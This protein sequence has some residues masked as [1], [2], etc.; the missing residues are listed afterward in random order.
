MKTFLFLIVLAMS[1][2]P[3]EAQSLPDSTEAASEQRLV[4]LRIH[5]SMSIWHSKSWPDNGFTQVDFLQPSAGIFWGKDP[6]Q[7]MEL[8]VTRMRAANRTLETY[9]WDTVSGREEVIRERQD[10]DIDLSLRGEWVRTIPSISGERLRFM[11]G[12]GAEASFQHT[13]SRPLISSI[14]FPRQHIG[15]NISVAL[16]ARM[17]YRLGDRWSFDFLLPINMLRFGIRMMR[18]DNPTVP[19]EQRGLN[20]FEFDMFPD[21]YGLRIGLSAIL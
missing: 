7:V 19:V 18:E 17:S 11:V 5:N 2:T 20:Y 8:Q 4:G 3:G 15:G 9:I 16:S 21:R 6:S 1:F 14:D 10:L 13:R 12:A